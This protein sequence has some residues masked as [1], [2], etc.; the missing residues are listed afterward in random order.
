MHMTMMC[1]R[2]G[3]LRNLLI[4][5]ALTGAARAEAPKRYELE[6]MQLKVPHAITYETG[7][8][9]LTAGSDAAIA[10]VAGYLADK[11]YVTTLRIEVHTDNTGAAAANQALT[12]KRALAVAR[13]LVAKGVDCKRLVP[14]GFGATKPIADNATADGRA[15]NRRTVFENAALRG[16]AI[17]GAPLD[18]GGKAA[19]DAC[20]GG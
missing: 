14:V 2:G 5:C 1:D 17:G 10:Y 7:K 11:T 20:A 4:V 13:A 3:M 6:G 9:A 15:A 8:A 12:E 19:G 16:K 18:G